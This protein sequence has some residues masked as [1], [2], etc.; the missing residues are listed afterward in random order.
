[1]A[2]VKVEIP[3]DLLTWLEE[4]GT[5]AGKALRLAAAFS[6]CSRGKL[7][8]SQTARL[9]GVSYADFLLAAVQAKIELCPVNADEL[10]EQAHHGFTL[11]RRRLAGHTTCE[12]G[13][14]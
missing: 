11:G 1:M 10:A 7:S 5:N 4:R 14:P 3:D 12:G 2:S 9:A 13:T 6:L 8:T